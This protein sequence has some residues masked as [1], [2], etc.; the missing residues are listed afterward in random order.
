MAKVAH[1]ARE[2]RLD[3]LVDHTVDDLGFFEN[4]LRPYLPLGIESR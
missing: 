3:A 2:H 1:Y 4:T